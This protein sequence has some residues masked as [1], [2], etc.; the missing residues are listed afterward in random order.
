M[1]VD[2]SAITAEDDDPKKMKEQILYSIAI[3]LHEKFC[4]HNHADGCGWYYEIKN[5]V[6][7]WNAY[8]HKTWL[9]WAEEMLIEN[10]L[11][12]TPFLPKLEAN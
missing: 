7:D 5:N 12:H 8:T 6:H 4:G 10:E 2:L 1:A 3:W 11:S 9:E